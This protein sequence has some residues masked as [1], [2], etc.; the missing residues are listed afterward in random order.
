MAPVSDAVQNRWRHHAEWWRERERRL[1]RRFYSFLSYSRRD[2]EF[3]I[4][5]PFVRRYA[6]LIRRHIPDYFPIFVDEVFLY[7]H[8][9]DP[10]RNLADALSN[11]DFTSAFISPGYASS[12]WC[13]FEW[14]ETV[15]LHEESMT[16]DQP[17]RT[18]LFPIVWKKVAQRDEAVFGQFQC[19]DLSE[20]FLRR[21]W[22]VA[23][24][25]PRST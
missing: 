25:Y 22:S 17:T 11:S 10:R 4:I 5:G 24:S 12:P 23:P 3:E 13:S 9:D 18:R 2:D 1:Q 7:P 20:E 19:L 21:E 15:R 14:W 8:I 16:K 6:E